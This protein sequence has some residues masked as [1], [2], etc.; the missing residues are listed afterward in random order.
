MNA[1]KLHVINSHQ[2]CIEIL[3]QEVIYLLLKDIFY[4]QILLKTQI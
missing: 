2:I 1:M 3:N 4:H